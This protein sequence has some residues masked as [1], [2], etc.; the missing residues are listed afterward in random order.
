MHFHERVIAAFFVLLSIAHGLL[1]FVEPRVPAWQ[2]FMSC[3]RYDYLAVDSHGRIFNIREYIPARAYSIVDH[4]SVPSICRW[5][6]A[7]GRADTLS[8]RLRVWH[9][10]HPHDM[11]M[12]QRDIQF[13]QAK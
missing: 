4:D 12:Q 2:M 9:G 13:V 10:L 5:L 3:D 6:V 8:V 7:T 1:G 11:T